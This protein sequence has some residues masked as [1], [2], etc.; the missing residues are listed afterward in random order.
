MTSGKQQPAAQRRRIVLLVCLAI[1][2]LPGCADDAAVDGRDESERAVD[3]LGLHATETTGVLR[4]FVVDEAIRPLVG[5]QVR[6]NDGERTAASNSDGAFGFD[7]LAP[8]GYFVTVSL[9]GYETVQQTVHVQAGIDDP[10]PVKVVLA[11]VAAQ[12]PYLESFSI[13]MFKTFA[14]PFI[15]LGSAFDNLV[16][17]GMSGFFESRLAGNATVIQAELVWQPTSSTA[18]L[19][20]LVCVS[21]AEREEQIVSVG[22]GIVEGPSPLAVRIPA[23]DDNGTAESF[24]IRVDPI[25]WDWEAL[26]VPNPAGAA[27]VNQKFQAFAFVFHNVVPRADWTFAADGPY[28]L[29]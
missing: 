11:S 29:P 22:V 9:P 28:P 13:E 25:E 23:R 14:S 21:R 4:G 12:A 10:P 17:P 6:L 26:Q 7:G 5:A 16:Q 18:Q 1:L 3:K 2:A 27:I 20:R 15:G 24:F 8:G 19:A